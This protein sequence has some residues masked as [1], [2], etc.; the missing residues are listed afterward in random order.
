MRGLSEEFIRAL[1][2][3]FLEPVLD[4]VKSDYTLCLEIREDYINIYYRG[5]NILRIKQKGNLFR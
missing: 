5:G 1:K 2:S 3:R 4:L